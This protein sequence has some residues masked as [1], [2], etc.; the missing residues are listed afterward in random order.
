MRY[1]FMIA[2]LGLAGP[3][4]G[5]TTS[6]SSSD[7][8]SSDSMVQY[9]PGYQYGGYGNIFIGN[10]GFGLQGVQNLDI[11]KVPRARIAQ[12]EPGARLGR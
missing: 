11:G 10:S 2:T 9:E 1:L 5:C 4:A 6:S 12:A 3:I 8:G 7:S